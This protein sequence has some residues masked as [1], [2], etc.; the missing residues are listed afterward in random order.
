VMRLVREAV[1]LGR[2]RG[3][4]LKGG[5]PRERGLTHTGAIPIHLVSAVREIRRKIESSGGR[6]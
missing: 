2:L 1:G 3:K 6:R 5:G 4:H